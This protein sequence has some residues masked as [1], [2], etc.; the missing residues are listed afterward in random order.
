MRCALLHLR[1]LFPFCPIISL[2]ACT[3]VTSTRNDLPSGGGVVA[4]AVT[5]PSAVQSGA[6]IWLGAEELATRPTSGPAWDRV[7][8]D[9]ARAPGTA[10]LGDGSSQHDVFT[11]AAALAC[12]RTGQYCAKARAQLLEAL[13]TETG[14]DWQ[15]VSRNLGAYVITADILGLRDDGDPASDGSRVSAWIA[16]FLTRTDILANYGEPGVQ[17]PRAIAPFHSGS[18]GAAH[19]GFVHAAVA[20]Y[21]GDTAALTRAWDAFRTY[22]CDP[23]APDREHIDLTKGVEADWEHSESAPC[24]VNPFGTSK[25]VP[26]GRP[27]A[28]GAHRIDGAIINDMRRGGIFQWPPI[29]SQYPWTG[30]E[31]FVPAAVILHR[32]GYPAFEAADRAVLR[33]IEYLKFLEDSTPPDTLHWFDGIRGAEVVQL[34]NWYYRT[35]YPMNKPAVGAARTIGYSDWTHPTGSVP[36]RPPVAVAGG[37]YAALEDSTLVFDGSGST[38]PDG[39]LPLSYF[40][41]FG[42][43]SSGTGVSPAHT[44]ATAGT[45]T[46]A[47]TVTDA[48]GLSSTPASTTATITGGSNQPPVADAGGPYSGSEGSAVQFD[49]SRS[50]DPDGD[51]PLAYTWSFGDGAS[52]TGMQPTHAYADDGSYTAG[53][54]V[55]DAANATSANATTTA[56]I[57]N[58]PPTVQGGA[59]RTVTA[60]E[61]FTLSASAADPGIADAPWTYFVGWG[62][63][64]QASGS[65][66]TLGNGIAATHS[67][68][69]AGSYTVG[70]EVTDKDG[71]RGADT[72]LVT[73]VPPTATPHVLVGAGDIATCSGNN[74]EATAALLDAIPGTVVTLGDNAY[75]SGTATEFTECYGP[76][77][78]RH[79]ARTHPAPGERDYATSGAAGYF[80]YFGAAAGAPGQG[81]YS[82]DVGSWHIVV[83]NSEVAV[84]ASSAQYAWLE[85]DLAAHPS[86]CAV[87]YWHRPYRSS[88]YG[89]RTTL[90][91][92]WDLLYLHGVDIVLNANDRYYER[93]APVTPDG[94]PSP[95]GIREFIVGTGGAARS[96]APKTRLPGSEVL[97]S[98]T[99][100]VLKLTLGEGVYAWEFVPIAGKTFS[101]RGS[102]TCAQP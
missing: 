50:T 40:W 46:V 8:I 24:A 89:V 69:T 72:V 47:L 49:G 39:D 4:N 48:K 18:N 94:T 26:D 6:G 80:G 78:G 19:E 17:G 3:D 9:A 77:W 7:L 12:A 10:N 85:A 97:N 67:Y 99:P 82:Y 11:L 61:V 51:L 38:D 37:P 53:L 75:K 63:G 60:G 45:Y 20:A 1:R 92:I 65:V 15:T 64:S 30:L 23:T 16:S 88:G 35:T 58:V 83:L 100:G 32:A 84:S 98:G 101:D 2:V 5:D 59:D 68:A 25:L 87:A 81:Y 28:G 43:G 79:R 95:N 62:D 21:V 42:D 73:V 56:T 44:Y 71:A 96:S 54:I 14:A 36:N 76:T 34:V 33:T 52:A 13:G 90:R 66:N 41:D 91:P 70:I 86:A 57:A 29:W 102:G 93:F 31:G 27:G 55:K 22:A 74:D